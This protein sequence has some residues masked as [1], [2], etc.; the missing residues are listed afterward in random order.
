[1]DKV[2]LVMKQRCR[3]QARCDNA[4]VTPIRLQLI[5]E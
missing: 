1:M 5:L 4:P 2:A 3:G